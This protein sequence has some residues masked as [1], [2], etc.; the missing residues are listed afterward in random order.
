M[1]QLHKI[2]VIQLREPFNFYFSEHENENPKKRKGWR[3][4]KSQ[5]SDF[6]EWFKNRALLSDVSDNLRTLSRGPNKIARRF[7]GYVVN[8]YRFH[9]KQR[10]ARRKTQNSGV[11][12]AAVTESFSSTKDENPTTQSITYYGLITQIVEVDYYGMLKLVLFRCDWFEAKEEKYGMTCVYFN[13]RCYVDDPFVLASQVHQCFY[14]QDPSDANKHY[15]MKSVPR[16][17][18]NMNEQSDSDHAVNLASSDEICDDEFVRNDIPPTI[19][20]NLEHLPNVIESDDKSKGR[21]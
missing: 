12:L 21:A 14:I 5:G 2:I 20:D 4:A 7:S 8:G 19:V 15:V 16:D 1:F 18:F 9:T 11:T 10:D 3:K 6:V 17:F 13:K